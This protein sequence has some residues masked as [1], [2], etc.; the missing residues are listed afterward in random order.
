MCTELE[1][2]CSLAQASVHRYISQSL[3]TS[4]SVGKHSGSNTPL[5]LHGSQKAWYAGYGWT[6]PSFESSSLSQGNQIPDGQNTAE[7]H[8]ERGFLVIV[9]IA[10]I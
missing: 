5:L 4:A 2:S 9:L 1:T 7:R 10:C 6:R 8:K 3:C